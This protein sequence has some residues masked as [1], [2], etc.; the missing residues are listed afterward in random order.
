MIFSR[1]EFVRDAKRFCHAFKETASSSIIPNDEDTDPTVL[2]QWDLVG[3]LT[4]NVYVTHPPVVCAVSESA[5]CSDIQLNASTQ[6]FEFEDATLAVDPD[7][8]SSPQERQLAEW[9]FSIVYSDT[10]MVPV[11]YFTVKQTDGMPFQ[12]SQVLDMLSVDENAVGDTWD[13][14]SYEEHPITGEPSFFLHPCQT[15]NR[16]GQ[17]FQQSKQRNASSFLLSW[18]SMTL[19]AVGFRIPGRTFLRVQEW[20]QAQE[21]EMQ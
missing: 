4:N 9:R 13:F 2:L 7:S 12:R 21:E 17:L 6:A 19:P 8:I 18:T 11:L 3:E 15:S 5:M 20:I 16:M 14:V 1:N 10:W